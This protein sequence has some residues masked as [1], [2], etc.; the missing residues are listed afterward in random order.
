MEESHN[1]YDQL[2]EEYTAQIAQDPDNAAVLYNKRGVCY[3]N[4]GDYNTAVAD[5]TNA[6]EAQGDLVNAYDNRGA[7]YHKQGLYD[8]AIIDCQKA[9]ELNP[10]YANAYY[11]LACNYCMQKDKE[12]ALQCL[13][14]ALEK[15]FKDFDHLEIDDDL[16]FIREEPG[17]K[18]L[19]E[20]YEKEP[21]ESIGM[22]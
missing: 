12:K 17:F 11:N 10:N 6:I 3:Y 9:L 7:S 19:M 14:N 2:I 21:L 18:T 8:Q 22:F 4:K 13:E 1:I 5:F 15:G 16:N 20:T